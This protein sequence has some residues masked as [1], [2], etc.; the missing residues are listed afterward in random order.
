MSNSITIRSTNV[1]IQDYGL[2]LF[3]VD[4]VKVTI[5]DTS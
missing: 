3:A 5:V 4:I 1:M 2:S